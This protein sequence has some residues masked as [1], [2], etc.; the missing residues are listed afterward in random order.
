MPTIQQKLTPQSIE[1]IINYTMENI[2]QK[3]ALQ[4]TNKWGEHWVRFQINRELPGVI[5]LIDQA[6]EGAKIQAGDFTGSIDHTAIFIFE[7]FVRNN[8]YYIDIE[9]SNDYIAFLFFNLLKKEFSLVDKA[10]FL[11]VIE[12]ALDYRDGCGF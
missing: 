1:E 12:K 9:K 7:S 10:L 3:I 5:E 6:F 11:K 8:Q 2:A 4:Q